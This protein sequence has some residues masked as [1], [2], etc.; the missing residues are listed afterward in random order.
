M[1][2]IIVISPLPNYTY[3]GIDLDGSTVGIAFIGTMCTRSSSTGLTQDGLGRS[4]S[5]VTSTAAHELGHVFNMNHD[6]GGLK[7]EGMF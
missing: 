7:R 2:V 1:F 4:L 5:S 6:D 3:S